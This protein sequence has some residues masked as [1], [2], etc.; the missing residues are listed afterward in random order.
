MN[1]DDF[2]ETEQACQL[3][4][5]EHTHPVYIENPAVSESGAAFKLRRL[6]DEH[7]AEYPEEQRERMV[8]AALAVPVKAPFVDLAGIAPD[9]TGG[10]ESA[11]YIK[12][13][14]DGKGD[15]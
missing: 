12:Q 3:R 8:A 1:L 6:F 4:D 9:F 10:V 2:R 13:R 5:T 14:W 11:A 15:E 7:L